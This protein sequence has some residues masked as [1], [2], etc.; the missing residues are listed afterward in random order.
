MHQMRALIWKYA[1]IKHGPVIKGWSCVLTLDYMDIYCGALGANPMPYHDINLVMCVVDLDIS[2]SVSPNG[3]ANKIMV[4]T[5]NY[6][7]LCRLDIIHPLYARTKRSFDVKFLTCVEIVVLFYIIK[8][9]GRWSAT[10]IWYI[11]I[12]G[13]GWRADTS[14]HSNKSYCPQWWFSAQRKLL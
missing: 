1:A 8:L 13:T 11:W 4:V 7:N 3:T 9:F 14:I 5:N 2:L 12:F 6:I 10:H